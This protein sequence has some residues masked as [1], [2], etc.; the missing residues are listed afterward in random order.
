MVGGDVGEGQGPCGLAHTRG[1]RAMRGVGQGA[2]MGRLVHPRVLTA[3]EAGSVWL[4]PHAAWRA[5]LL[6]RAFSIHR[7]YASKG[8]PGLSRRET[9]HAGGGARAGDGG[10][11]EGE[12]GRGEGPRR[13]RRSARLDGDEGGE[14][15]RARRTATRAVRRRSAGR[16]PM[17]A[18]GE[19]GG[20][21]GGDREGGGEGGGR[22]GGDREG[23][24]RH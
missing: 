18:G 8:V 12:G 19:G 17:A 14:A 11:R 10:G 13:R 1:V 2:R 22:E 21:E 5:P 9:K 20:R 24:G 4:G 6:T 3:W 15:E 23:G 7:P 16:L